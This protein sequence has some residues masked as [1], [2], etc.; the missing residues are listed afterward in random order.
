MATTVRMPEVLAGV[1]EAAIATWLV[2]VGDSVEVGTPLAEVETEK[3]VVEYAS[4]VAGTVLE[5][6]AEAG[7]SVPIGAPIALIGAA[8]DQGDGGAGD[9]GPGASGGSAD[10][11]VVAVDGDQPASPAAGDEPPLPPEEEAGTP[12]RGDAAQAQVA[13]SAPVATQVA[14]SAAE[15]E[16]RFVSPLVRRLARERGIDLSGVEGTGPNGRIVRRDLETLAAPPAV[17]EGAP[18]VEEI[19]LTPMRRAIARRLTESTT[20]VPHFSLVADCRVDRLLRLRR[21]ANDGSDVRVSINDLV[22]KAVAGALRAVPEANVTWGDTVIRRHR[23]VDIALAVAVEGGLV[24]PVVR[25]ADRLTLG[26]LSRTAADLAERAR[27][28]RLKQAELEGGSFS[29]SNLG[30]YGTRE[31]SA[32]I[33]PPHAGILAVGAVRKAPIVEGGALA[34]GSVMTIT[35]SA[36]HRVLD[37][38]LAAQLLAAIVERIENP[39]RAL[40]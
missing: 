28:G 31:F 34:V 19:P 8:G 13:A 21:E 26:E 5:L 23:S 25:D 40:L 30:M 18:D 24:T 22:V 7:A 14:A 33:N 38:A 16:R 6:R 27:A 2:A 17:G 10:P 12:G 39:V 3:A 11:G 29:V 35:L 1:T 4:E 20:T 37:G 36:D 9:G 15:S 32:I